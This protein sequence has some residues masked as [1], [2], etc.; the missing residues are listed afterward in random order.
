MVFSI[1]ARATAVTAVGV[2]VASFIASTPAVASERDVSD[3]L[4]I[5]TSSVYAADEA[6][7]HE[8][9]ARAVLDIE[10]GVTSAAAGT[11]EGIFTIEGEPAIGNVNPDFALAYVAFLQQGVDG[12]FRYEEF[13]H[14]FGIDG[15]WSLSGLEEG[16]YRVEF[17]SYQGDLPNNS[18][19]G[20]TGAVDFW[21]D[22]VDIELGTGEGYDFETVNIGPREIDSFRIA[23]RSRFD[24]AVEIT[25]ATYNTVP[26]GGVPVVYIVNGLGFAD[27]LSAGPAA[28]SRDGVLL[29]VNPTSIPTVVADELT[30]LNPQRIIVAGGS[31][32][33]SDTVFTALGAYSDDVERLF[34]RTRYDTSR[35]IVDEAFGTIDELFIVTGRNFPD[36]LS[37]GPA[38]SR[39]GGAVLLVDGRANTIDTPTRSLITSLG[40]P[41]VHLPGS[42]LVLSA[43]VE[44]AITTHIAPSTV[45]RYAGTSRYDTANR[46][47]WA[48]FGEYGSDYA[49]IAAGANFP[50]SLSGGPLAAM[51]DAPLYLSS[52]TCV[53][54][55]TFDDILFLFTK[56][57]YVLGSEIVLSQDVLEGLTC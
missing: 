48:V 55:D 56:E 41:N 1:S 46:V 12:L 15:S 50:D 26:E 45:T 52:R 49:V 57:V 9:G 53:P 5:D 37:A 27:A 42:T 10:G 36:A 47:N 32:V 20:A 43:G 16:T 24:T 22:S 38:A 31:N 34:G 44:S 39:L 21:F 17:L 3:A 23:G 35:A 14:E 7:V 33:V 6:I 30:R 18:F 11:V 8:G 2:L 54:A 51:A 28:A 13:V 25:K 29:P 40:M 19:W 4:P